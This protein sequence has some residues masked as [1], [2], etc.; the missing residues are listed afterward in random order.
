M[1]FRKNGK[2]TGRLISEEDIKDIAAFFEGLAENWGGRCSFQIEH[3]SG[4]SVTVETTDIFSS[5]RFKRKRIRAISFHY[6]G[7]DCCNEVTLNLQEIC[8]MAHL[9]N[10]YEVAGISEKWVNDITMRLTE[11]LDGI[12]RLNWVR[13]LI[14]LPWALIVYLAYQMAMDGIMVAQGYEYGVRPETGN[15][16]FIPAKGYFLGCWMIFL[17]IIALTAYLYPEVE[18]GF[19][20][21]RY[22]N[23]HTTRKVIGWIMT[24]L[25][26][27]IILNLIMK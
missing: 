5:D 3:R 17:G 14:C 4:D 24:S 8:V 23:R 19:G 22:I 26:V 13:R 25:I 11:L 12:P 20:A 16:T 15:Y 10:D 1:Y 27:P 21:H 6:R 9:L 7:S 2:L 18:F